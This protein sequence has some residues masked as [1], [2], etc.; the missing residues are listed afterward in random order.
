M[1]LFQNLTSSFR[2]EEYWI[3]SLKSTQCKRPPHG[4]HVFPQIKILWT[5]FKKGH[6]KNNLVKLLQILTSCFREEDFLKISSCPYSANA[7]I[8][9]SH[10]FRLIKLSQTFFEKGHW[11]KIP[12]KLLQNRTSRFRED[13]LRISSYL[14]SARSPHSPEPCLWTDQNFANNFWKE[15]PKEHYF[16]IISKSD[17]GFW[18]QTFVLWR[19][20]PTIW[21]NIT[22]QNLLRITF[23]FNDLMLKRNRL[24]KDFFYKDRLIFGLDDPVANMSIRTGANRS[25]GKDIPPKTCFILPS[26]F[27]CVGTFSELSTKLSQIL[28]WFPFQYGR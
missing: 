15:S 14:Y 18:T 24:K 12:V 4:G 11:R 13:F 28:D 17:H 2:G 19:T 27:K 10:V 25:S 3:I 6:T 26:I 1:K 21:C 20:L 16:E 8:H 22:T 23:S 7:P 9:Q 5:I